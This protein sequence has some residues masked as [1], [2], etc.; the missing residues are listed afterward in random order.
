M[1]E[2]INHLY[3]KLYDYNIIKEMS[4]D[5][6]ISVYLIQKLFY[7]SIKYGDIYTLDCIVQYTMNTGINNKYNNIFIPKI[8]TYYLINKKIFNN[9]LKCDN[10]KEKVFEFILDRIFECTINDVYINNIFMYEPLILA[11]CEK[12]QIDLLNVLFNKYNNLNLLH[13]LYYI[14]CITHRFLHENPMEIAIRNNDIKLVMLLLDNGTQIY[15][16]INLRI[17]SHKNFYVTQFLEK[18]NK[19]KLELEKLI[20]VKPIRNFFKN[21]N[22]LK[23][24]LLFIKKYKKKNFYISNVMNYCIIPLLFK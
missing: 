24:I 15:N 4:F 22:A 3:I 9:L 23:S 12:S 8:K 19:Y 13:K 10:N 7:K 1:Q 18:F 21:K 17:L 16:D 5:I 14:D 6:D 11:L 2:H 20:N